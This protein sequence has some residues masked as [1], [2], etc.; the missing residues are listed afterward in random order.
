ML[1]IYEEKS[2][3]RVKVFF[4]LSNGKMTGFLVGDRTIPLEQGIQFY[5]D[6]Y[7]AEQLDKCELYIDGL[8]PKLRIKEGESLDIPT[9]KELKQKEIEELESRLK[10]L[11]AE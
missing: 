11:K 6:E 2:L 3:G 5:V 1:K 4:R 10:Q 9:E 8:T 7:I